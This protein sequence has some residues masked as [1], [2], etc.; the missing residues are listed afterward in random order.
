MVPRKESIVLD[1][2]PVTPK[3]EC[4]NATIQMVTDT[5]HLMAMVVLVYVV[6]VASTRVKRWPPVL[7]SCNA[8]VTVCVIALTA[9]SGATVQMVGEVVTA[10][11]EN[12]QR[13][14]R[15][16]PILLPTMLP[17]TSIP[18]ALIWGGVIVWKESVSVESLFTAKRVSIWLVAE[19]LR[20]L[21][22]V[23]ADACR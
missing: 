7:V 3:Q 2:G 13:D 1:V 15:G 12:V 4:V 23:T 18:R 5:Y 16:P 10:R 11:R 21:V 6:T 9:V 17:M 19:A 14:C 22:M 20:N 8:L